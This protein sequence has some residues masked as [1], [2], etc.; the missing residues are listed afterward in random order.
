MSDI[1]QLVNQLHDELSRSG[2]LGIGGC[3]D[4]VVIQKLREAQG[5]MGELKQ[6]YARQYPSEPLEDAL[7]DK[8]SEKRLKDALHLYYEVPNPIPVDPA[9]V[10]DPEWAGRLY[11][12][13]NVGLFGGTDEDEVMNVLREA[14]NAGQMG[15]LTKL[16]A[17]RYP[18]ELS[19]EDELYDELSGNELKSAL[20]LYYGGLSN[21]NQQDQSMTTPS[22]TSPWNDSFRGVYGTLVPGRPGKICFII[23]TVNPDEGDSN[24]NL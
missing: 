16:Y 22:S 6:G 8:L 17:E 14:Y 9:G 15:A 1:V 24:E 13:F 2:V 23:E 12:A 4:D 21:E 18:D 5:Q 3:D 20:Q 7:Y 19:L 10:D 11:E